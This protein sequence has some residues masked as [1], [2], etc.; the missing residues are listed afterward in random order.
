MKKHLLITLL[1]CST[2]SICVFGQSALDSIAIVQAE[3]EIKETP[4][5][6]VQKTLQIDNLYGGPQHVCL[7]E[8]PRKRRRRFGVAYS[9]ENKMCRTSF[10]ASEKKALAAINGSFYNMK[11]GNSTCYLREENKVVDTTTIHEA[12][13]RV[14]AAVYMRKSRVRIMPWSLSIEKDYKARKG[15]TLASGPLLLQKGKTCSWTLCDSSFVASKHPRSA[16]YLTPD[17]TSVLLTVDGRAKGNAFGMSIPELAHLIRI[18]GGKDAINLDGGG[19][20][21]LWLKDAPYDGVINCPSDN[22][23]FD[24]LGERSVSNIIYV[25]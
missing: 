8:V 18:L 25:R 7:V 21:T 2:T 3:W 22:R 14:N 1:L 13:L 10:F 6:L 23:T 16:L 9:P 20:T 24:H 4:E 17:G 5:G 12:R 15:M 19:S 11:A